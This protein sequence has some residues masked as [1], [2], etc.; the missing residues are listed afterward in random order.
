MAKSKDDIK[1]GTWQARLD[2]DEAVRV[3][4]KH[5]TPLEGGKIVDS[6]PVDLF[7]RA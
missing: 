5:S 4:Y 1:C 6:K 3:V 7:S 2:D